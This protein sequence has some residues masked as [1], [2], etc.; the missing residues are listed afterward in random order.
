MNA[1]TGLTSAEVGER[2]ARGERNIVSQSV[3]RTYANIIKTNVLNWFNLLLFGLGAILIALGEPLQ[4]LAASGIVVFN[5]LVGTVQEVRAKR[6]LDKIALLYRPKALVMREGEQ[7]ELFPQDIV[8]D[9]VVL[10][11][12]GEQALV[13]GVL[14]FAESLEIDESLLTGE[15][16]TVKKREGD[17]IY[18]GSFCVTGRGYFRVTAFGEDSYAS[19]MLEGAKKFDVK[20]TPLQKETNNVIKVLMSIAAVY[21]LALFIAAFIIGIPLKQLTLLSVIILDIVPIA[22]FLLIVIAYAMGAVRMAGSGALVQRANAVESMSHVDTVCMDKTGTITTNK[23]VFEDLIRY[24]QNAEMDLRNFATVT[25]SKNKTIEAIIDKYPAAPCELLEEIQFSSERK[26]SAVRIRTEN[27]SKVLYLGA[28]D[29]LGKYLT[30]EMDIKSRV[31]KKSLLGLRVLLLAEM[32][33]GPLYDNEKP[34]PPKELKAVALITVRDE[35]RPDCRE[36][37]EVFLKNDM[38][39]KIIS[40]DDPHTVMAL[41]TQASIPG[42]KNVISGP[43]LEAL[44]GQELIDAVL[45]TTIFGRMRPQQKE[46]VIDI[47]QKQGRYVAMVGDGVNDVH[48]LKKANVGVALESGSGAARGV[49]DIVLIKDNFNAL[50]QALIEGRRVVNGMKDVLRLYLARNFTLIFLLVLILVFFGNIPLLPTNGTFYAFLAVSIVAFLMTLWSRPQRITESILPGVVRFALPASILIAIFGFAVY[51]IYH[52]T[53]TSGLVNIPFTIEQL[54]LF[55]ATFS[56]QGSPDPSLIERSAELA[57]RNAMLV[58]ITLAGI[59]LIFMAA[60]YYRFLSVDGEL[61]DDIRPTL[62]AFVLILMTWGAFQFEFTRYIA[63]IV[64]LRTVD[65]V[66]I[67]GMVGLWLLTTLTVLRNRWLDGFTRWTTKKL[68]EKKKKGSSD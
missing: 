42:A 48:S 46:D 28:Y 32:A 52:I 25:G 35:V 24:G 29:I 10:L 37:I 68:N 58:F 41:A 54:D 63:G 56:Y 11:A 66:F 45:N 62:L 9:D 1:P 61:Y 36:T 23:M 55:G 21:L 65:Y 22:L 53:I 3:S 40:G 47:L 13:D 7:K 30:D 27:Y 39:I 26:Y 4:A 44:K 33:D 17:D 67:G 50:P 6:R 14:L 2:V 49:A 31:K 20:R 16:S 5:V 59:S 51:S 57:A 64:P 12:P 8:K 38:D 60:P 43:E 34:I 15:S 18:S 19:K